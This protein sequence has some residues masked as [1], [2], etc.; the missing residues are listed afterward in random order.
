M[1]TEPDKVDSGVLGTLVAVLTFGLIATALAVT[2]LVRTEADVLAAERSGTN[3]AYAEMRGAQEAD[4]NLPPAYMDQAAGVV[5]LPIDRA[6]QVVVRDLRRNPE[7]ATLQK[8]GDHRNGDSPKPEGAAEAGD[9]ADD[10]ELGKDAAPGKP[11]AEEGAPGKGAET[12]AKVPGKR[13]APKKAPAPT[14]PAPKPP[15]PAPAPVAPAPA[16]APAP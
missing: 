7:S 12:G 15:T 2:A 3:E 1:A 8:P 11:E 13:P 14:A 9:A 6:M 16:P 5:R 10:A 4:L